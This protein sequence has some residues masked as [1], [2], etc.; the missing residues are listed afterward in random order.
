VSIQAA[1]LYALVSVQGAGQSVSELGRVSGA[2][3]STQGTL[4]KLT[5]NAQQVGKGMGQVATG[6]VRVAEWA[7]AAIITAGGAAVRETTSFQAQM[8]LIKTQAGASQQEV[9]NQ[10]KAVQ[11]LVH[12]VGMSPDAL[13]KGLYHIESVGVRGAAA[14]DILKAAAL[15]ANVGLAD[16]ESVSNALTAVWFSGIKG[17]KSMTDAVA[18]LDGIVGVGNMRMQDITDSFRSGILGTAA[19]YGIDIRSLGAAI[20]T[21]TDAGVPAINA[22]TRLSMTFTHMAAPTQAALKQ[23]KLLGL[24]QYDL[25]YD[26]RK[27][28]GV[29]VALKDLHDHLAKIGDIDAKGQLTPQGA[30]IVSKIFGGSRFGASAMQLLNQMD[31]VQQKYDVISTRAAQFSDNVAKTMETAGFSWHQFISDLQEGGIAFGEGVLPSLVHGLK[32]LDN[33]VV[34][35]TP[36]IAN[37]GVQV[38][39]AIDK[40]DWKGVEKGAETF[41]GWLRTGFDILKNIPVEVDATVAAFLGLNKLSGGLLGT[42]LSNILGGLLKGVGNVA[43]GLLSNVPGV[44]GAISAATATRVFIVGAAPGVFGPGGLGPIAPA[45]AEGLGLLGGLIVGGALLVS[46]AGITAEVAD[47]FGFRSQRQDLEGKY[48][49]TNAQALALQVEQHGGLQSYDTRSRGGIA[50]AFIDE[51]TNYAEALAAAH[52]AMQNV[53]TLTSSSNVMA[54]SMVAAGAAFSTAI[55]PLEA[56]IKANTAAHAAAHMTKPGWLVA[57]EKSVHPELRKGITDA[58]TG[59]GSGKNLAANARF[60]GLNLGTGGIGGGGIHLAKETIS[61]LNEAR[62]HTSDPDT[63]AAIT[64]AI[65][66]IEGRMPTL[67]ANQANIAAADRIASSSETQ[68]QKLSDLNAVL[69]DVR[70]NGDRLTRSRINALIAEVKKH[71]DTT[72]PGLGADYKDLAE[73]HQPTKLSQTLQVF[74]HIA[75][76]LVVSG[77]ALSTVVLSQDQFMRTYQRDL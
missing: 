48:N 73:R 50:Q 76:T 35:H 5:A 74:N 27:P 45:A 15:G 47:M 49:L 34:A 36:D 2:V 44:G 58:I 65:A 54:S 21:L 31:R 52:A 28:D 64:T 23:F 37:L 59:L 29:F 9:I 24:G 46:I 55:G 56:A 70:K 57:W 32:E 3:N 11:D 61:L 22:A 20:A 77:Q 25:A 40:I 13:A 63:K 72:G 69:D 16:M 33:F 7:A 17:A 60:L 4:S 53:D 26:L 19:N 10:T 18:Q 62:L 43:L 30:S 12:Q 67:Q 1:N 6:L 14:L 66:R 68:A 42:G 71:P 8:E 39:A 75:A 38:G 51:H 41:V